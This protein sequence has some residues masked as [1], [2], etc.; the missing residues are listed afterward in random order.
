MIR[1]FKKTKKEPE[2]LK[3]VLDYFKK[4][5]KNHEEISREL[6]ELKA[7][8]KK[9]LQKLGIVRFN[10]FGEVGGDQSFSI[11]LLDAE[12]NGFV[13]TSHYGREMNRL[14]AKPI[15]NGQSSYALSKEEQEAISRATGS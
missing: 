14:Y 9:N 12:N 3:E 15:K 13:I 11:A 7:K 8:N 1:F 2:S 10:P 5:E 6:T 4:I